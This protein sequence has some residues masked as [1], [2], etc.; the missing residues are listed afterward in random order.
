MGF[1]SWRLALSFSVVT[2][3]AV[4][5]IVWPSLLTGAAFVA[6]RHCSCRFLQNRVPDDEF[7]MPLFKFLPFSTSFTD[8]AVHVHMGPFLLSSA[9]FLGKQ[10]G[11]VLENRN[12][13]HAACV[14]E[15]GPAPVEESINITANR[16]DIGLNDEKGAIL[17]GLLD[18]EMRSVLPNG[19]PQKVRALV[20][21]VR[22]KIV[23]ERY[24]TGFS[25]STLQ[26]CQKVLLCVFFDNFFW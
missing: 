18:E 8:S 9:F 6:K 4:V 2:V 3:A 25:P 16:I 5:V 7:A 1:C 13:V 17:D 12:A 23:G 20:V 10:H 24:R 26:V 22:G 11:C 21:M 15:D 19:E 14:G